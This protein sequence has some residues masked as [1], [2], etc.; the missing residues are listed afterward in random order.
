MAENQQTKRGLDALLEQALRQAELLDGGVRSSDP[1]RICL[2]SLAW[3][4]SLP[5]KD[6]AMQIPSINIKYPPWLAG[7]G[8]LG[9]AIPQG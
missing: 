1:Q 3:D 5:T 2:L 8:R 6:A 4:S 9:T 7:G